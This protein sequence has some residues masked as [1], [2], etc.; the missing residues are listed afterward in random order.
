LLQQLVLLGAVSIK[1]QHAPN[2]SDSNEVYVSISPEYDFTPTKNA[3]IQN[4]VLELLSQHDNA[5]PWQEIAYY[6]GATA[7]TR[8][9]L[10]KQG[11]IA[12]ESREI[13]RAPTIIP[14]V[15]RI[16]NL[17][18]AQ[19]AAYEKLSKL[20]NMPTTQ[21]ALLHGVTGSGKTA[22]YIKLI[23]QALSQGNQALVLVPEIALTP[24]LC[25]IFAAHFGDRVAMQTSGMT[26]TQR[27]DEWKRIRRGDADVVVGT[28]SAVFAPLQRLALIII[29]EEHELTYK[30]DSS[31]RY[32]ARDIA[33]YR[34]YQHNALLVLGSATPSIETKYAAREGLL[35]HIE[36]PGRFNAG[37]MPNVI[38]ANMRDEL[39]R[40]NEPI[41]GE[42]LE[43][44][45]RINLER[46][47]QSILFV[48]R[49][50]RDRMHVCMAC[51][52][53]PECHAC[54]SGLTYHSA[55]HRF[56]CHY[57]D[58]SLP[59]QNKCNECGERMKSIG[60]G[61]QRVVEELEHL[62]PGNAVLRMDT[63]TTTA[64]G[65]HEQMLSRFRDEKIPFL[66][67]T[68]M[69]T[70]GLD[71]ENV[72]LVGVLNADAALNAA[73]YRA[74]ERTFGLITQVV[75]RAGR[76][77]K[78]GR[79]VLQTFNP[80]NIILQASAA[81][82]YETFYTAELPLRQVRSLPPF[83][84]LILLRLSGRDM[85]EVQVLARKLYQRMQSVLPDI[86]IRE[87][88]P[89]ALFRHN[90]QYRY[91][92]VLSGHFDK[93]KRI[94]LAGILTETAK[95]S[96]MVHVYADYMPNSL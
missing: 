96:K 44:E 26:L 20:L 67:G 10:E 17:T 38:M 31:P 53:S 57:C 74:H 76:G 35:A 27:Y 12:I 54:S 4:A 30:S 43:K 46:G 51:A 39:Q 78:P 58:F 23:E 24:Q 64:R 92:I 28:R 29:D 83:S 70:K 9:A 59:Q 61:T 71:F 36:L 37:A 15:K 72:T 19:Q 89:A 56:M 81:Q 34:A 82:D 21:G 45:L 84:E 14:S 49:R 47:Q 13:M 94:L 8:R 3:P 16:T 87:P 60:F 7:V 90:Y 11:A 62:F 88:A 80:Q 69:I 50:G 25:S 75:G 66:I 68:Q 55:N 79:A 22:V 91:Q 52:K 6:T 1:T 48:N 42:I 86:T 5:I 18:E 63:D 2:I 41:I 33:K 73:D 65:A 85:E 40:G 77:Q 32:H 95:S 93:K